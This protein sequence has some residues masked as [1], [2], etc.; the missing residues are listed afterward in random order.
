VPG[1]KTID[2]AHGGLQGGQGAE[3]LRGALVA[4]VASWH[5]RIGLPLPDAVRAALLKVP[6]DVFAPGFSLDRAYAND[7]LVTKTSEDGINVSAVSAPT[8]I[9]AMLTQAGDLLGKRVLEIGSGG[10]NAALLR[11]LVGPDGAVTTIDIDPEIVQRARGCLDE[12]GY[13]DVRTVCVDGEYGVPESAPYDVIL[14][15]AGAWDIPPAWIEQLADGGLIVLPLR[16]RGLTRSWALELAGGRLTSRNQIMCGFVPMQGAGEHRGRSLPLHEAGVSLWLDELAP[17]GAAARLAGVLAQPRAETWTGVTIGKQ[18]SW[19]DQ[20]VWLLTLPEFCLLT[21][22]QEAMDRG[23][24]APSWRLGTPALVN[25]D[26]IAYRAKLRPV[27]E[28]GTIFEFGAYG[29]GP[30]A[31]ELAER[32]AEQ[33][34]IWD[35]DY[36]H[37]PG[38]QLTVLPAGTRNEEI[39]EGFVLDKR[40]TKIVIS[41]AGAAR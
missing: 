32:L 18:E 7:S 39:P 38:P 15:T 1:L 34:C 37:G 26:S 11:E 10:Y 20:D 28:A 14:V 8:A 2:A 30:D 12:A 6:R 35:R 31:T 22:R 27:D 17:V 41:W 16:T 3:E 29:H 36:R 24:V 23:V 33:I 9:S 25:G 19:A 5:D 40:H 21:A 13:S 4:L